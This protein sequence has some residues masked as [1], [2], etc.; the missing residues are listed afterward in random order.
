[1]GTVVHLPKPSKR[2]E[3]PRPCSFSTISDKGNRVHGI[4]AFL[5]ESKRHGGVDAFIGEIAA[6]AASIALKHAISSIKQVNVAPKLLH[7][8]A[9]IRDRSFFICS[10]VGNPEDWK[11]I[12]I[13]HKMCT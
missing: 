11:C 7:K 9:I 3:D 4:A 12:N 8:R 1:M 5:V 6:D 13:M 2:V 10:L